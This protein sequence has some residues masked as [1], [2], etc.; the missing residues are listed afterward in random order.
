MELK[1]KNSNMT[2]IQIVQIDQESKKYIMEQIN[3]FLKT[4][5]NTQLPLQLLRKVTEEYIL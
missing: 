3:G 2:C 5:V 1:F 4:A